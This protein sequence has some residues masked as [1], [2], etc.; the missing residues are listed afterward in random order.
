MEFHSAQMTIEF[1]PM[2]RRSDP[3][4]SKAAAADAKE[5]AA[6]HQRIILSCL[7]AHG[8]AGKDRIGALTSLTGVAVCRRLSE[9][10]KAG[11]IAPTGRTVQST[12][13]RAER[14]WEIVRGSRE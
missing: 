2:A 6:R 1:E 10:H 4:T 13:G 7:E 5:I 11:L 3:A 14:E 8:P 12:S 9:M